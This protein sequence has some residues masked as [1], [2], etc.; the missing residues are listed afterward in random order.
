M[1]QKPNPFVQREPPFAKYVCDPCKQAGRMVPCGGSTEKP[2]YDI[3]KSERCNVGLMTNTLTMVDYC[4]QF[5]DTIYRIDELG[6]V[7]QSLIDSGELSTEAADKLFEQEEKESSGPKMKRQY[8]LLH[9]MKVNHPT[10]NMTINGYALSFSIE[11]SC[12]SLRSSIGIGI[13][14][15][16][17]AI[18]GAFPPTP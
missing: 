6:D 3:K 7:L 1:D 9:E 15:I 4:S 11:Y 8:Q 5:E 16:T 2:P 13:S 12:R 17:S 18:E 10:I 14:H